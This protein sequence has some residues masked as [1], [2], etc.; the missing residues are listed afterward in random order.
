MF[1][2]ISLRFNKLSIISIILFAQGLLGGYLNPPSFF[3]VINMRKSLKQVVHVV[4]HG[5]GAQSTVHERLVAELEDVL[6]PQL[7]DG[8]PRRGADGRFTVG[9]LLVEQDLLPHRLPKE[10]SVI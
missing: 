10:A 4:F 9:L 6:G 3:I 1:C 5:F 8:A 7:Q 2:L